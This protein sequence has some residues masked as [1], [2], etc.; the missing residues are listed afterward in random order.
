MVE[1]INEGTKKTKKNKLEPDSK[2]LG[3]SRHEVALRE[4]MAKK[5]GRDVKHLD[6]NEK[7]EPKSKASTEKANAK[8]VS[9]SGRSVDDK[10][11]MMMF[12]S[13]QV[14]TMPDQVMNPSDK[15]KQLQ[16]DNDMYRANIES[17][18]MIAQSNY[19]SILE[20]S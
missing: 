15:L 20:S 18:Q 5:F 11:G 19:T 16:K 6:P 2:Y 3:L 14:R 12:D 9:D 7:L 4:R 17:H 1:A 13:M 10:M 8:R